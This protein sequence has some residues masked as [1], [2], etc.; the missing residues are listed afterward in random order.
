M[1][2]YFSQ[3]LTDCSPSDILPS[4]Q[5]VMIKGLGKNEDT[6]KGLGVTNGSKVMVIGCSLNDVVNVNT[7]TNSST[8]VFTCF[9]F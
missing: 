3:N 7:P 2:Y 1:L 6:L 9:S 5:K 8:E 4:M